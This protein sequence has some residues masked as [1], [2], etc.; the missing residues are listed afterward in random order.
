M[1]GV[2]RNLTTLK[3]AEPEYDDMG[4]VPGLYGAP[5]V[6]D[7]NSMYH[8]VNAVDDTTYTEGPFYS[9][10]ST[11]PSVPPRFAHTATSAQTERFAARGMTSEE[12]LI[13]EEPWYYRNITRQ[14]AEAMITFEPEGSFVVRPSKVAKQFVL[15]I[16]TQSSFAHT[17]LRWSQSLQGWVL[18]D[19][20]QAH[21]SVQALIQHHY[22]H[23]IE[24][25]DKPWTCLVP[26]TTKLK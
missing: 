6:Y 19:F 11:I 25:K 22:Q 24:F 5:L 14:E 15:S 10:Q 7:D 18:G 2:L 12:A 26:H 20:R 21:A 23:A 3:M 17:I 13:V 8:G 9:P 1:I 16:K 4:M